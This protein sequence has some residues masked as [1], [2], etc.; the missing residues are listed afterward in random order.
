MR[1]PAEA[2]AGDAPARNLDG[3]DFGLFVQRAARA[4]EGAR[5]RRHQQAIVD[6]PIRGAENRRGEM[7][8][9]MRFAPARFGSAQP[10]EIDA[11]RALKIEIEFEPRGVVAREREH[12]RALAPQ[13]HGHARRLLQLRGEIGPQALAVAVERVE[14]L[15]ARLGLESGR[16]HPGRGPAR[17]VPGRATVEHIDRAAGLRQAPADAQTDGAAADNGDARS[18]RSR[19]GFDDDGLPSLA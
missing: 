1:A 12:Q 13:A 17:A 15:L 16:Q 7:R 3:I 2:Q 10:R 8:R 19:A 11:E 6:L 14:R 5:Q 9:E 4:G 18:D